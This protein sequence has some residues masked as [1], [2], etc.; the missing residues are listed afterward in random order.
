MITFCALAL[1]QRAGIVLAPRADLFGTPTEQGPAVVWIGEEI[2]RG[3]FAA[4]FLDGMLLPLGD[5][6]YDPYFGGA[7]IESLL[8]APLFAVFG[9]GLW[10]LKLV[11]IAFHL[12]GVGTL[13]TVLARQLSRRAAVFGGLLY[14][15]TP[16]GHAIL[17]TVAWGS[18][19]ESNTLALAMLALRTAIP[20]VVRSDGRRFLLGALMGL[21][22]YHGY[23]AALAIAAVGSLDLHRGQRPSPRAVG[24]Q[25]MG[26]AVGFAPWI[27]YNVRHD[28]A[29]L[30]VYD[31]ALAAHLRADGAVRRTVELFGSGLPGALFLGH[32]ALEL[33][34]FGLMALLVT[35]GVRARGAAVVVATRY[36]ALFVAAC[37]ATDFGFGDRPAFVGSFR[38]AYLTAPWAALLAG[39]GLDALAGARPRLRR[40]AFVVGF[41]LS[42]AFLA[43]TAVRACDASRFL[44]D[45]D[46][47]GTN[48]GSHGH[49]LC[50]AMLDQ[51]ERIPALVERI[52]ERRT[53][54]D[55]DVLLRSMG[56]FL[57]YM[58]S[59]GPRASV[60]RLREAERYRRVLPIFR[61]A[62][63]P[64]LESAFETE[65]APPS[66][67]R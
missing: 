38:Y 50:T 3:N 54:E 61:A 11:P 24:F 21:A 20:P 17:T 2:A 37:A 35:V 52:V 27:V 34:L 58:A 41:G 51:P 60:A 10:T 57:T 33:V 1:V 32:R 12:V 64:A 26:F 6:Q 40:A 47:P 44:D 62:V 8:A 18:H 14:A 4:D 43:L 55:Q 36:L 30:V 9:R 7:L 22:L 45:R 53:A 31:A 15:L 16:P 25:A 46:L 66:A 19:L 48:L 29:G 28:F 23:Q 56:R 59:P 5:Y 65:G 42:A 13:V 49:W 63:P 67:K 39:A